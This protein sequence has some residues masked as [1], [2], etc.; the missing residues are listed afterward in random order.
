MESAFWH[1]KW[2]QNDIG[3]HQSEINTH[4]TA[5]FD[6]LQLA[7]GSRI[8]VPLCGK[9]RDLAWLLSSNF[10]VVGAELNELAV[11]Q[12]FDDLGLTPQITRQGKL[13]RY[14]APHIDIWQ[15]DIFDLNADLLGP[16]DAVYD[17]AALVAL[18]G[19]MRQDYT[20][21]LMAI[22]RTAP[23]LLLTFEYDQTLMDGPPFSVTAQH[24]SRYYADTYQVSELVREPTEGKLRGKLDS[25]SVAW[26]LKGQDT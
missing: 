14:Q 4:L 12:L 26:L 15:G 23:Q 9:T 22:T 2:E 21:H 1:Q 17:R 19:A 5:H 18:P 11:T 16:V 10:R 3:F 20:A 8:F 25:I 6:K 24:I 13:T 7:T